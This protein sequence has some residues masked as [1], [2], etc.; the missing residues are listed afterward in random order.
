MKIQKYIKPLLFAIICLTVGFLS[1]WF[2]GEGVA[3]TYL[4]L[5]RPIFAPPGWL[6][7]PVWA[8][9]YAMMGVSFYLIWEKRNEFKINT[10]STLFFVQLFLNFFWSIIFFRWHNLSLAFYEILILLIILFFN[11]YYFKKISK[12]AAYLLIPYILWVF[13]ATILT[14]SI[15]NLN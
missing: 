1:S 4:S 3:A 15:L 14:F 11:F 12:T 13:F 5:T 8:I 9:L 6:F 7:G 2:T 10:A